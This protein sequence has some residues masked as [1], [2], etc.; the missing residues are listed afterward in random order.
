[1]DQVLGEPDSDLELSDHEDQMLEAME[2]DLPLESQS[3]I[4]DI[5]NKLQNKLLPILERHL[6]EPVEKEQDAKG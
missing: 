5:Q 2:Q 6:F 1:M 4:L 3:Q